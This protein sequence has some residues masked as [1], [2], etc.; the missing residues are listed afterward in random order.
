MNNWAWDV[1]DGKGFPLFSSLDAIYFK[2]QSSFDVNS[3]SLKNSFDL[4]F[5][6]DSGMLL[7]LGRVP[8]FG[9]QLI[10]IIIIDLNSY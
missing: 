4:L 5:M 9:F 1:K 10:I 7:L 6:V 2:S 8:S 3:L